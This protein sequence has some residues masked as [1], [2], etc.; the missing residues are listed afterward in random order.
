MPIRMTDTEIWEEDWFIDLPNE[1]KLF[2]LY[3]KDKCDHSGLWRPNRRKFSMSVHGKIMHYEEFLTQVNKDPETGKVK[4]RILV[5]E[6]GKWFITRFIS[7]QLGGK[8]VGRIG[9]HRGALKLLITNGIH[10][11]TVP[12]MDWSG[13]ENLDIQELRDL[14]YGKGLY[15]LSIGDGK[16]MHREIERDPAQEIKEKGGVGEKTKQVQFKLQYLYELPWNALDGKLLSQ[17]EL[18]GVTE[19]DFLLWKKFVDWVVSKDYT[20]LF[21]AIFPHP[22]DFKILVTKNGFRNE[23]VWEP[24]VK[25]LLSTGIKAEQNLYF[26][27]PDFMKYA[28]VNNNGAA[29]ST[30]NAGAGEQQYNDMDKW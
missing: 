8:Y 25:K 7:F 19:A 21:I 3:I 26:R 20:S 29:S 2:Y 5:L 13:L 24:V 18:K 28:K 15:S 22:A 9:A 30:M 11:K 17:R 23:E 10:P 14:A 4:N 6:N 1:Y 27:I 16:A 12:N